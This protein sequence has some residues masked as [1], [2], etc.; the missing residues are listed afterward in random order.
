MWNVTF[1]AV[2]YWIYMLLFLPVGDIN[3]YM[4]YDDAPSCDRDRMVS[5]WTNMLWFGYLWPFIFV[6]IRV[7]IL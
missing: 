7:L 6:L 4:E 1:V 5:D 2:V 3:S